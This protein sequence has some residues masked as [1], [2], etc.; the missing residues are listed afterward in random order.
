MGHKI[1]QVVDTL[2]ASKKTSETLRSEAP[3][4]PQVEWNRTA[5][6]KYDP[7]MQRV[8]LVHLALAAKVIE[9]NPELQNALF[10]EHLVAVRNPGD[11]RPLDPLLYVGDRCIGVWN[12]ESNRFYDAEQF[13]PED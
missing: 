8:P 5:L 1:R 7:N 11:P 13:E 9:R 2:N 12:P 3:N 4:F 6:K 10:I